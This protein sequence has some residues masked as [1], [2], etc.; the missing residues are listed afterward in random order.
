MNPFL[1]TNLGPEMNQSIEPA[2]FGGHCLYIRRCLPGTMVGDD[3]NMR[4]DKGIVLPP[5]LGNQTP[6]FQV[7]AVGRKFGTVSSLC[8]ARKYR[9]L[10]I[11]KATRSCSSDIP[12]NLRGSMTMKQAVRWAAKPHAHPHEVIGKRVFIPLLWPFTDERVIDNPYAT[13]ERFIEESLPEGYEDY[14]IVG[15]KVA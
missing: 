1:A 8:H 10:E 11:E 5:A 9:R 15:E 3:I 13:Y 12:A 14:E 4:A 7:V 2:A 6:W